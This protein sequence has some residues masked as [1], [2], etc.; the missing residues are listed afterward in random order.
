MNLGRKMTWLFT[1]RFSVDDLSL[2]ELCGGMKKNTMWLIPPS[3]AECHF[4]GG[5]VKMSLM[6]TF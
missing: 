2:L 4:P 5:K 1:I 3:C 6:V